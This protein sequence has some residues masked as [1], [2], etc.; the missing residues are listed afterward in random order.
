MFDVLTGFQTLLRLQHNCTPDCNFGEQ[1]E[2][3]ELFQEDPGV[4]LSTKD[5]DVAGDTLFVLHIQCN[6]LC[7]KIKFAAVLK[8][9]LTC[10]S[11]LS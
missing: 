11:E 2:V 9:A 4:S 1:M 3:P 5:C 6:A 8:I 10:N 7:M